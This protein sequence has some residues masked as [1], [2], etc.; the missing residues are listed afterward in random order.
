V[1]SNVVLKMMISY[2]EEGSDGFLNGNGAAYHST[3]QSSKRST[4]PR[5]PRGDQAS[6]DPSK[7][8]RARNA[9]EMDD[10]DAAGAS[11]ADLLAT[12]RRSGSTP[13]GPMP[14]MPDRGSAE[15]RLI[16]EHHPQSDSV[17]CPTLLVVS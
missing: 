12:L 4:T 1:K 3:T 8:P 15:E 11:A 17:R 5:T 9:L 6:R 14:R 10:W 7:T 13:K 2:Q 16:D